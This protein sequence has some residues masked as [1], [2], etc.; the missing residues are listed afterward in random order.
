[1]SELLIFIV[2]MSVLLALVLHRAAL[3]DVWADRFPEELA[4]DETLMIAGGM[5]TAMVL[6]PVHIERHKE[7]EAEIIGHA[8]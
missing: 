8:K 3:V 2:I 1:M 6:P 7:P 5:N 4:K